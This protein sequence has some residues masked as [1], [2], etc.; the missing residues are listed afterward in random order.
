[1][2][3]MVRHGMESRYGHGESSGGQL[4]IPPLYLLEVQFI[5][6]EMT[7]TKVMDRF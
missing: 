5:M 7:S 6:G 4:S 2:G 3:F 1:M